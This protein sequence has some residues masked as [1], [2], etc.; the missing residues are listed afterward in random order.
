M[1]EH[2]EVRSTMR[3]TDQCYGFSKWFIKINSQIIESH[4]IAFYLPNFFKVIIMRKKW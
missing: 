3:K 4:M 2:I 1:A